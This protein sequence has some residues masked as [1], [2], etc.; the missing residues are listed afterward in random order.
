MLTMSPVEV[1]SSFLEELGSGLL[2]FP[3]LASDQMPQSK[4][5]ISKES[6]QVDS[7]S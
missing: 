1:E 5:Q 6:V 2:P 4:T 3:G 7:Q